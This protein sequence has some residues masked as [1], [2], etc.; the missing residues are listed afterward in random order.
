MQPNCILQ[1]RDFQQR[2]RGPFA[3]TKH[4][5]WTFL[6]LSLRMVRKSFSATWF[7]KARCT[8][9]AF[10]FWTKLPRRWR[11]AYPNDGSSILVFVGTQLKEFTNANSIFLHMIDVRAPRQNGR[12]ERHGDIYKRTFERARWMHSEQ[13]CGASALGYGMQCCQES[14]V[15]PFRLLSFPAS[16]RDGTPCSRGLDQ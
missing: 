5:V 6:R 11:S 8:N 14:T 16:V 12:T 7:V 9:C 1:N 4:L 13:P 10:L 3:S 15:Q 2:C